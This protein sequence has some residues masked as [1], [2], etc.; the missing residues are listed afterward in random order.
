[1]SEIKEEKKEVVL[2]PNVKAVSDLLKST[3]YNASS[4]EG[5]QT[6][7][8]ESIALNLGCVLDRMEGYPSTKV[9]EETAL[10][11]TEKFLT[12]FVKPGKGK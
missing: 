10:E 4:V 9:K 2:N 12:M 8:L 1:M 3:R 6:L 11:K 5:M 7:L